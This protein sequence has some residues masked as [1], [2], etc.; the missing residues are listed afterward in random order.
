MTAL[1]ILPLPAF[2]DNY[3]WCLRR[4]GV[5]AV[6]DPGDA[7]PVL[8]HLAASGD[9][10]C[11]ILVTHHHHDHIDGIAELTAR[12]PVPVFAPGAEA[13]AGTTQAVAGGDH[14]RLPELGIDFDVLDLAGHTRGH[15]GYYRPGTLFCGDT[16]FG[17]G[18]GRLFEG[19]PAQLHAALQ[20]IGVL[21]PLT[22]AYCAHE[23]TASG[24]RF[25]RTVEPGNAAV[26]TRF[27]EITRLR[28]A[29]QPTVPFTIADELA[30][31]PFLRCREPEVI[32]AVGGRLA[33]APAG[34][35]E[36]FASL[37]AWRDHF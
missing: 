15:V 36:V 16:L 18:C 33:R 11:A 30:T 25:A 27:T 7:A 2:E 24:I 1:E 14:I 12:H 37:R 13:I 9:R 3:I 31:N 5:V 29:G 26:A 20:R 19:T 17:C 22:L 4:D 35:L 8:R 6:V 34:E 10:L 21:P 23:Y 28:A 32:A